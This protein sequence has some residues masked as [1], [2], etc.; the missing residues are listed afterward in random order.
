MPAPI[1]ALTAL[2]HQAMSTSESCLSPLGPVACRCPGVFSGQGCG[3]ALRFKR[4]GE[5][6]F[7]GCSR[8]PDCDY[9]EGPTDRLPSPQVALEALSTQAFTVGRVLLEVRAD[10]A[11]P[12]TSHVH[13]QQA[14][15]QTCT[16]SRPLKLMSSIWAACP[17]LT[18]MAL[19]S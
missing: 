13:H 12:L 16:G 5:R 18:C 4:S 15:Y 2:V 6:A 9:R 3:A 11:W 19:L 10:R 14:S 17:L 7:W 1:L 8:W